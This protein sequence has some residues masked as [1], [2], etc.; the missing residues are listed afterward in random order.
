VETMATS[1]QYT[2]RRKVK[3]SVRCVV[4]YGWMLP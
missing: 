4:A 3:N 2:R 1:R